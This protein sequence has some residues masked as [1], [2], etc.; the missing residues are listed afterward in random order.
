[1]AD[2]YKIEGPAVI[3]FSGGRT[4]GYMLRR[5]LDAGL[6]PNVHIL[7]ADTQKER[8]ETYDFI[9]EIEKRWEVNVHWVVRPG[10]FDKL[11]A[12]RKYLPNPVTRFCTGDLK[13]KTMLQYMKK[14]GYDFWT[15]VVGLRAD[16][17]H[18]V[19][20]MR[21]KEERH[22]DYSLPLAEEGVTEEDVLEWWRKQPFDLQ[23]NTW[24][25]NCDLCFL[26]GREKKIRIILDTP[27]LAEWW[28]EQE[29]KT[30]ATF[31]K[32]HSYRTLVVQAEARRNQ[33]SFP[34]VGDTSVPVHRN[35][36]S[37]R[38]PGSA[39]KSESED[40]NLCLFGDD[41]LGDC[42]CTD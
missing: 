5:I 29:E 24:E 1:M 26:K 38:P 22:W 17:P 42:L 14:R 21:S 37:F 7:F 12:D 35:R 27:E 10:G 20:R 15:N 9:R 40:Q 25:G 18:R 34:I 19:A 39:K 6:R 41:D 32:N 33:L 2:P 13:V 3:S 28:I 30:N 31:R 36:V 16:K 11:I 23:L 4:S 8:P